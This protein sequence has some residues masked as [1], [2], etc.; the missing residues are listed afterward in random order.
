MPITQKHR[1]DELPMD[2]RIAG[3]ARGVSGNEAIGAVYERR[4]VEPTASHLKRRTGTKRVTNAQ[5][6]LLGA[7][8]GSAKGRIKADYDFTTATGSDWAIYGTL[9]VASTTD[10][11]TPKYFKILSF[12]GVRLYLKKSYT[13][14]H[15]AQ[16]IAVDS[17]GG[18]ITQS[19]IGPL[20]TANG[21]AFH[22]FLCR[23]ESGV[24]TLRI[25]AWY[26]DTT[27]NADITAA[28]TFSAESTLEFFGENQSLYTPLY[29]ECVLN[30]VVIYDNDDFATNGTEHAANATDTTPDTA[31][32]LWHD[33]FADGGD[34]L[35]HDDSSPDIYSYLIPTQPQ[36]YGTDPTTIRF[37]GNGTAEIPFYLDF[38]EYFWTTTNA[39][40]RVNWCFQLKLTTP[41][42][43][44]TATVFE[45]QDLARLEIVNDSGWKLKATF[46]DGGSIVTN[47][48][49]IVG[50]T[51]Y[52]VFV[53]RDAA[54]CYLKVD[55]T[56]NNAAASNPIIYEYDKTLG[57]VIGDKVDFENSQPFGGQLERFALH[58][59]EERAFGDR[60][61]AV[62]YYD[63]NSVQGDE[64]IDRGNRALNGYLG[65]RSDTQAPFYKQGGFPGGVIRSG[66]WKLI[67]R[68]EDGRTHLFNLDTDIHERSD[69]ARR[70][71]KRVK[72]M[73]ARL[74]AWYGEVDA[75][76][77][78]A[79]PN[80]PQPWR[81]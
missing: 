68:Y 3:E 76:F 57:F 80:G 25:N 52:D 19:A 33:T 70:Y 15:R 71:P 10:T 29:P 58:N 65:V 66:N 39:A 53:A 8:Y 72:Q 28:H 51:S 77:L 13:T 24:S 26:V 6:D 14:V 7:T 60:A 30:N 61:D 11:A 37:G 22:F 69:L 43:L 47:T 49:T 74:H 17:A 1:L 32:L 38:D 31:G 2:R 42:V 21:N 40:A 78:K 59:D 54:L 41:E 9:E 56:E 75:K 16:F 27:P 34:V 55:S 73:R 4:E 79:K 50:G 46:N 81:P 20:D 67:E 62:L 64:L 18:T 63:V 12:G 48:T 36:T 45:L 44:T 35:V 23:D 5:P